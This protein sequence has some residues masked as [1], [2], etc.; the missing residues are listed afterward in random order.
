MSIDIRIIIGFII[1][2]LTGLLSI[3]SLCI[4]IIQN[5]F[6]GEL[7]IFHRRLNI[8][9]LVGGFIFIWGLVASEHAIVSCQ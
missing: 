7:D 9:M 2:L 3:I 8:I 6:S 5:R 4:Q 1:I